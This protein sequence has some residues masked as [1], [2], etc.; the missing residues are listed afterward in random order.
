[1]LLLIVG[2]GVWAF[3]FAQTQAP[4]TAYLVA[5]RTIPVGTLLAQEDLTTVQLPPGSLPGAIPASELDSVVGRVVSREFAKGDL[6]TGAHLCASA[7]VTCQL[8]PETP[9]GAGTL[10]YRMSTQGLLLPAGLQPGDK[11]DL[12]L[13]SKD[14]SGPCTSDLVAGLPIITM[15][16][17]GSSLT[18]TL[19]PDVVRLI[20]TA[21]N[22]GSLVIT[23][24]DPTAAFHVSSN[25]IVACPAVNGPGTTPTPTPNP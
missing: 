6:I 11:V 21:Q 9:D 5:A 25:G 10:L 7:S 12:F 22:T 3:I 18:F 15:D 14:A 17:D 23:G 1:V 19:T 16:P 20:V 4:A 13:V 2:A 8:L 24:A